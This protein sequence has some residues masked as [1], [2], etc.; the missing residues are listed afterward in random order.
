MFGEYRTYVRYVHVRVQTRQK[1]NVTRGAKH[2]THGERK[3]QD[4][5]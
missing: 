1:F 2:K 4:S 5:K 3:A